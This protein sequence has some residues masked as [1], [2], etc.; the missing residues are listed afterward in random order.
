MEPGSF[1]SCTST[2]VQSLAPADAD[3]SCSAGSAYAPERVVTQRPTRAPTTSPT[4]APSTV[5]PDHL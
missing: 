1:L 3:I 4:T 5:R 2:A